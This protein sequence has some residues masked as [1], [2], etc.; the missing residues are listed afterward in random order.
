ML[1]R[2]LLA[3]LMCESR[4]ISLSYF[5]SLSRH[6]PLLWGGCLSGLEEFLHFCALSVAF[7]YWKTELKPAWGGLLVFAGLS[8][9]RCSLVPKMGDKCPNQCPFSRNISSS[10]LHMKHE[11]SSFMDVVLTPYSMCVHF[12]SLHY[13][14]KQYGGWHRFSFFFYRRRLYIY[15]TS[16][17]QFVRLGRMGSQPG[18]RDPQGDSSCVLREPQDNSWW[19]NEMSFE[20][21]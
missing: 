14:S 7:L 16:V 17:K 21:H 3:S 4:L 18:G 2:L 13:L 6:W 8:W 12:L 15:K 1:R 10:F 19:L 20:I 5:W 11:A 9:L